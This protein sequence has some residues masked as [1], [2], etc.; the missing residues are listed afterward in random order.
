MPPRPPPQ[1][2]S[3]ASEAACRGH[4]EA[5]MDQGTPAEVPALILNGGQER[6][7][8]GPR[9]PAANDVHK[10]AGAWV[11]GDSSEIPKNPHSGREGV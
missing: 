11:G 9:L 2:P 7:L 3:L 10:G 1:D 8:A 6:E 5:G 4:H